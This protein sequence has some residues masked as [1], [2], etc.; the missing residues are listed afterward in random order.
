MKLTGLNSI[1]SV[2]KLEK[3]E[4]SDIEGEKDHNFHIVYGIIG[5][6]DSKQGGINIMGRLFNRYV[7]LLLLTLCIIHAI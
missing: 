1:E 6:K 2:S 4:T 7:Q 5:E 3:Y